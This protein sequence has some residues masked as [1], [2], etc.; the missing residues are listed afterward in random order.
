VPLCRIATVFAGALGFLVVDALVFRFHACLPFSPL[1][2]QLFR[3]AEIL[4]YY[5]V[6]RRRAKPAGEQAL[7]LSRPLE[8]SIEPT[9]NGYGHWCQKMPLAPKRSRLSFSPSKGLAKK[10]HVTVHV[11]VKCL[12]QG[13]SLLCEPLHTDPDAP[14]AGAKLI[15]CY[16]RAYVTTGHRGSKRAN[17]C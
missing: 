14:H 8:P 11:Q 5:S 2:S 3:S 4:A 6:L 16:G 13:R 17:G 15:G 10:T 7:V 9:E 12:R 1:W